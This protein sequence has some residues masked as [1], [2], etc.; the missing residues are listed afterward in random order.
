MD[1]T[2]YCICEQVSYGEMVG[3]DND[4][5]CVKRHV[6]PVLDCAFGKPN[7][8]AACDEDSI[9]FSHGQTRLLHTHGN[10]YG[11]NCLAT[12]PNGS[13]PSS[14]STSRVLGLRQNPRA[15]GTALNAA[16]L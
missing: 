15:S 10:P 9:G 5:V 4:D 14:G 16:K 6:I 3:C 12:F 11:F 1:D 8:R 7:A 13:A 2:K